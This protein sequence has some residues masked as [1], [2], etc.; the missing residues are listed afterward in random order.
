MAAP[1]GEIYEVVEER[2]GRILRGHEPYQVYDRDEWSWRSKRVRVDRHEI[3]RRIA[4]LTHV[5]ITY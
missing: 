2:S 5:V 3:S 4:D 1:P